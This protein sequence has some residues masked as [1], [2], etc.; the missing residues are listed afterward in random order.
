MDNSASD[1]EDS[2][3]ED[4]HLVIAESP[5]KK[6]K[7][8]L[9]NEM[10]FDEEEGKKLDKTIY[11]TINKCK[12]LTSDVAKKMLCKLVKNDHIL[13]LALLKAEEEDSIEKHEETTSHCS[14][15]E[16]KKSE[17]EIPMT[18]KLTRLK[19][20]QL[21]KKLTLPELSL[22]TPQPNEEVVKLI[23]EELK[24]DEEDDEEYR[25]E[26]DSDGDITNLTFSDVDSQPSTPGSA[27]VN[28]E[29]SP[30]K[31]GEFK[32]PRTPLTTV[33][34]LLK[35]YLILNYP[36]IFFRRNKKIFRGARDRSC[37]CKQQQSKRFNRL[38]FHQTL[39]LTCMILTITTRLMTLI[40][41]SF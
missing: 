2:S 34:K 15:E 18:P 25:P 31:D 33:R 41:K 14:D 22:T 5:K 32:V 20:K 6:R 37:A 3:S 19:A 17:N 11:E 23:Q 7:R 9:K 24:S 13:A 26:N 39:T 36:I 29:D 30:V 4:I 35:F 21:N 1:Q 12:N 40:G 16:D 27:L 10:E 28:C 38:S 8:K